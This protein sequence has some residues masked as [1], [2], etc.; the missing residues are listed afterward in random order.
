MKIWAKR[1]K[2]WWARALPAQ[3]ISIV[4]AA[5]DA[6]RAAPR[7]K[8]GRRMNGIADVRI[9]SRGPFSAAFRRRSTHGGK[10]SFFASFRRSIKG[11]G[12]MVAT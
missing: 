5:R 12:G 9:F 3:N 1:R 10:T 4:A 2:I 6:P 11:G 8:T 7:I